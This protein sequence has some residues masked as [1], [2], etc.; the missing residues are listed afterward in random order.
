MIRKHLRLVPAE[1]LDIIRENYYVFL[2]N[3]LGRRVVR[4]LIKRSPERAQGHDSIKNVT[5]VLTSMIT[6]PRLGWLFARGT[7]IAA[8]KKILRRMGKAA[9]T[10]IQPFG[11]RIQRVQIEKPWDNIFTEWIKHAEAS[12]SD[13]NNLGDSAWHDDPLPQALERH[14]LPHVRPDSVVLELG[15]GTGRL[16]RHLI[17]RCKQL[18]LVDYSRFVCEWLQRYLQG[19]GC[20]EVHQ[21]DKPCI[22]MVPANSV[23]TV[24]ANG[25][26]EHIDVDDLYSFLAEFRRLLKP[27]GVVA[28]NFDN[29]TSRGGLEHFGTNPPPLGERRIF[30]FYH[31]EML[32]ILCESIGFHVIRITTD[33]SRFG[34]IEM[35]KPAR[36]QESST[37]QRFRKPNVT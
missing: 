37:K 4:C 19:K 36:F 12:G 24:L 10:L 29:I 18:I 21:I 33:S 5:L 32:R 25:V 13:P 16:T 20:F 34:F 14:Y 30:R 17:G 28:F 9:N 1:T 22:S 26:F 3:Y 11:V 31:P 8:I 15:P 35:K 6:A 7:M 27:A 23:D 2:Y